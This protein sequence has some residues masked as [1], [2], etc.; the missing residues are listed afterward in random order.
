MSGLREEKDSQQKRR[1][2]TAYS[3]ESVRYPGLGLGAK[4]GIF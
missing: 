2:L 4:P 1:G 3:K